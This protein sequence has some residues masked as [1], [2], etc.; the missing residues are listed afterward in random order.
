MIGCCCG[1]GAEDDKYRLHRTC[2]LLRRF[3]GEQFW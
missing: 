2:W 1:S 3:L